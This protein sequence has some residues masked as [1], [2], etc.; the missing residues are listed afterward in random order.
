MAGLLI[1]SSGQ[2]LYT[3]NYYTSIEIMKHV[4]TKFKM[5]FVGII[6]MTDKKSRTADDFPFHQ[7]SKGAQ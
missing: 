6:R 1:G 7:M 4:W 3:D 5:L 2:I